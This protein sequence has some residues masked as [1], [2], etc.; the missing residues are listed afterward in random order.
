MFRYWRR[1]SG[2][3]L[4]VALLCVRLAGADTNMIVL[5]L[6]DYSINPLTLS[7]SWRDAVFEEHAQRARTIMRIA[8][9][10]VS[11]SLWRLLFLQTLHFDELRFAGVEVF[12]LQDAAGR[13]APFYTPD[14]TNATLVVALASATNRYLRGDA[15]RT[16]MKKTAELNGVTVADAG[17][18]A[19]A[20]P[21]L[22]V[23]NATIMCH[24]R[25]SGAHVWTLSNAYFSVRDF[26]TPVAENNAVWQVDC[27]A[28]MDGAVHSRLE[29]QTRFHSQPDDPLLDL[30]VTGTQLRLTGIW[31]PLVRTKGE[32]SRRYAAADQPAATNWFARCFSNEWRGFWRA[33]ERESAR[34]AGAPAPSN[35]FAGGIASNMLCDLS[36]HLV[37]SNRMYLPGHV[38]LAFTPMVAQPTTLR[39]AYLITNSAAVLTPQRISLSRPAR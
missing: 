29:V 17:P 12:L 19:L 27:G 6:G 3:A 15:N 10:D 16:T 5:T 38:T 30:C 18:T 35:F 2:Q 22:L 1:L 32:T 14:M 9:G 39:I 33:F 34:I 21:E 20:V 28:E 13:L 7:L 37:I 23:T 4:G 31:A 36:L 24:A 26:R 25:E 11:L 8:H